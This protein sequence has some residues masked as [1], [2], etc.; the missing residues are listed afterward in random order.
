[1]SPKSKEK[2]IKQSE[3]VV[4]RRSQIRFAPYNPKRHT[5]ESIKQQARNFKNV[6]F[7]GGIVWNETTGNLISGHKR[8]M[9][10]DA[11]YKNTTETPVD[12]DVKVEKVQLSEK[13]EK[14]QNIFMDARS[15]NTDQDYE[16]LAIMLP[17]IDP[18]EAGLDDL[19]IELIVAESPVLAEGSGEQIK[20]EFKK[21]EKPYE[22]RK[23]AIKEMKENIK[24]NISTE[25]GASYVTLSFD[26][27]KNKAQFMT[28]FGYDS[29]AT[30]IK[31]EMFADKI[32]GNG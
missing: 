1:M 25:Q 8:I 3:T 15:T 17:E 14:E 4:I 22:E 26:D 32:Q 11:L 10:M 28:M 6:G 13:Q 31:G 19:E 5:E 29:E 21:I 2:V 27:Y 30:V 20:E 16:L 7:L 9:A 23:A 24:N 18:K 12:Y